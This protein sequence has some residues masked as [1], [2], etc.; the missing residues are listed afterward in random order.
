MIY[1]IYIYIY[2]YCTYF[3]IPTNHLFLRSYHEQLL[4][5]SLRL[6]LL[7]WRILMF[8][9]RRSQKLGEGRGFLPK[10]KQA[11]EIMVVTEGTSIGT[12]V[13]TLRDRLWGPLREMKPATVASNFFFGRWYEMSL[14]F[15]RVDILPANWCLERRFCPFWVSA[16][17]PRRD[18]SCS[19]TV[20]VSPLV[21]KISCL[22][23]K[24]TAGVS[25]TSGCNGWD[26]WI[27]GLTL[28]KSVLFPL[29]FSTAND[30]ASIVRRIR[31]PEWEPGSSFSVPTLE[32]FQGSNG[33]RNIPILQFMAFF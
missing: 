17:F 19:G 26:V 11:A 32:T 5:Y 1:C 4:C 23:Q 16:H 24:N 18:A 27:S 9:Q 8:F 14:K 15:L 29:V 31:Q 22:P 13:I 33:Q 3:R 21:P 12:H 28:G 20:S 7:R 30:E 25:C 10:G 6:C 2:T